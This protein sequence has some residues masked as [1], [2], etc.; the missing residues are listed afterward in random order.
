MSCRSLGLGWLN[1]LTTRSSH[2][3]PRNVRWRRQGPPVLPNDFALHEERSLSARPTI[4]R[5]V[6]AQPARIGRSASQG[7]GRGYTRWTRSRKTSGRSQPTEGMS[8]FSPEPSTQPATPLNLITHPIRICGRFH[9]TFQPPPDIAQPASSNI[10]S[11]YRVPGKW[12]QALLGQ[13]QKPQR[14][15]EEPAKC[16]SNCKPQGATHH[17]PRGGQGTSRQSLR[18]LAER[19]AV[20]VV[21][22]YHKLP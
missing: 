21:S 1:S 9:Q 13:P 22:R 11:S 2:R 4:P 16:L 5:P 14:W 7:L 18:Q 12:D 6:R 10:A 8:E 15:Y 17:I 19:Q 3:A 20:V